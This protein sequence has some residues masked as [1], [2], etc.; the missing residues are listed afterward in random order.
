M[1]RTRAKHQ[2]TDFSYL[3]DEFNTEHSNAE[4]VVSLPGNEESSVALAEE[5]SDDIKDCITEA[6]TSFIYQESDY[7]HK[8]LSDESLL[9]A[10]VKSEGKIHDKTCC[11]L[12]TYNDDEIDFVSEYDNSLC[13]CLACE[14]KAVIRIGAKDNDIEAHENFY[15]RVNASP[16]FIRKI[17]ITM[18]FKTTVVK[19]VLTVWYKEDVWKIIANDKS[20]IVELKHNNYVPLKDKERKFV[21]GFHVQNGYINFKNAI[22][23]IHSYEYID[24]FKVVEPKAKPIE[25]VA[26]YDE[27]FR[28]K[29]KQGIIGRIFARPVFWYLKKFVF[30]DMTNNPPLPNKRCMFIYKGS[31]GG[32][33]IRAGAY[34]PDRKCFSVSYCGKTDKVSVKKVKYWIVLDELDE[35]F[36][37]IK[38]NV[39]NT[40][41]S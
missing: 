15:K 14:T 21:E 5:S 23:Y 4:N 18:G 39:D 16:D 12:K 36:G 2:F 32:E 29:S 31:D 28:E 35:V 19:N 10:I 13:Q 26:S 11:A 9:F 25:P 8:C 40:K 24:H 30:H 38:V 3:L 1:G 33:R 34:Q 20:S 27:H 17:Y 6:V 37:G 22:N 41:I 7:R